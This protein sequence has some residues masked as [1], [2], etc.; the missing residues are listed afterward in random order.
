MYLDHH[1]KS[2]KEISKAI[3][4]IGNDDLV[5]KNLLSQAIKHLEDRP[6][7]KGDDPTLEEQAK[8]DE[9]VA[10]HNYETGLLS[11]VNK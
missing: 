1:V 2:L 7:L 8:D 11:E 10:R 3:T 6:E 5:A 9:R 4:K